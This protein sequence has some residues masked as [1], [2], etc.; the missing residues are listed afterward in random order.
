M[1]EQRAAGRLELCLERKSLGLFVRLLTWKE[2]LV[3]NPWPPCYSF[4]GN[5]ACA[6]QGA[7]H[8]PAVG[9]GGLQRS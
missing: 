4:V 7:L 2:D 5:F 8:V 9:Y 1:G 6:F 3:G